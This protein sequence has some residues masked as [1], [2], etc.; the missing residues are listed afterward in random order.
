MLRP[1]FLFRHSCHRQNFCAILVAAGAVTLL[2]FSYDPRPAGANPGEAVVGVERMGESLNANAALETSSSGDDEP[3]N[4]GEL[5]GRMAVLMQVL[6]LEKG[7]ERVKGIPQYTAT[8]HKRERIGGKL[9]E[10]Q[11][12]S[13]KFRQEP[14]SVYL[15]WIKGS[16]EG[17]ELLYVE[18]ENDNEMMVKLGSVSGGM[19]PALKLDPHGSMAMSK[20]RYPITTLGFEQMMQEILQY[21]RDDL[22]N[23]GR[24]KCR[25]LEGQK[26]DRR[27]CYCFLME[28]ASKEK[29]PFRKSVL[30]IDSELSIPICVKN[31][32]WGTTEQLELDPKELDEATLLEFY[33]FSNI[34]FNA[35]LAAADFDKGNENYRFR[36]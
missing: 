6:L 12:M 3:M 16:D 30:Y 4:D 33:S 19:L 9:T 13:L 25:M 36:R 15:K 29:S 34:S 28:Y 5:R 18:G 27:D 17:Q 11:F 31:F 35:T 7:L 24:V 10:D 8:F 22:A 20:A 2:Y 26:F 1:A 32:D 21:R 23:L 14:F